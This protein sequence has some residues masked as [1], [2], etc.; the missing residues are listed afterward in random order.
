M[1]QPQP[2]HFC[3]RRTH[4]LYVLISTYLQMMLRDIG[5]NFFPAPPN[6][7]TYLQFSNDVTLLRHSRDALFKDPHRSPLKI[8]E[9]ILD[10]LRIDHFLRTVASLPT[11]TS[12]VAGDSLALH[13]DV[14]NPASEMEEWRTH[15]VFRN[16]LDEVAETLRE[17]VT[18]NGSNG[19]PSIRLAAMAML[20]VLNRRENGKD[21]I[22]QVMFANA[23][24]ES[25]EDRG[26]VSSDESRVQ[27][28]V[29]R[30]KEKALAG[31]SDFKA[32]VEALL[33]V[34]FKGDEPVG[35]VWMQRV[36]DI[37]GPKLMSLSDG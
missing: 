27:T 22:A 34:K 25:I 36:R 28:Y 33:G 18:S 31:R 16:A 2:A 23:R 1:T 13:Q 17:I 35:K 11:L 15:P 7:P 19:L 21:I 29:E 30:V 4:Q 5:L 37:L 12:S 24:V 10:I 14:T 26:E 8:R 6:L 9:L 3:D 20:R 32:E